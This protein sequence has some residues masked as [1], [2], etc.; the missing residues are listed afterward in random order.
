MGT[1]AG[2]GN[3]TA[4]PSGFFPTTVVAEGGG[5]LFTV[6]LCLSVGLLQLFWCDY[7]GGS[8]QN[9]LLMFVCL[10]VCWFSLR[11][12]GCICDVG[13]GVVW[14]LAVGNKVSL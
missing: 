12:V 13:P 1:T 5:I 4:A 2:L 10:R 6:N 14:G 11:C 7:F 8:W 9:Y 3:V